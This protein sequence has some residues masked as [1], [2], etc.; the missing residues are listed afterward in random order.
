MKVGHTVFMESSYITF[1]KITISWCEAKCDQL[2]SSNL[3]WSQ[4][5][6]KGFK[7]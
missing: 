7:V 2:I 5:G 1:V 6:H 3:I 4:V